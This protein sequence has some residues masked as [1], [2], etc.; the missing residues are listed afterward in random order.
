MKSKLVMTTAAAGAAIAALAPATAQAAPPGTCRLVAHVQLA[1]G[2]YSADASTV[3]CAGIIN[4]QPVH[5]GGFLEEWGTYSESGCTLSWRDNT[6]FARIP[7][8]IEFFGPTYI[9]S[10]G[11]FTFTGSGP[12]MGLSGS[13][14][15]DGQPF[16]AQGVAQFTPDATGCDVHSGTLTQAFTITDGGT[17]NPAA[18][19]AINR[20]ERTNDGQADTGGA[21]SVRSA[22]SKPAAAAKKHRRHHKSHN[23]RRAA[24]TRRR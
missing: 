20:Y 19:D 4:G 2:S 11:A 5:G 18:A 12:V 17:G 13:G 8:A 24:R 3:E 23:A 15:N 14:D 22:P 9:D 1:N 7:E 16:L 10:E 6:F 21:S